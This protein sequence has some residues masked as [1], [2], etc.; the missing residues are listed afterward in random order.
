MTTSFVFRGGAV[1]DGEQELTGDVAVEVKGASIE[2]VG[3][4]G[5]MPADARVVDLRGRFL[6]PGLIDAHV[7]IT[8]DSHRDHLHRFRELTPYT[9]IRA[10]VFTR[11]TLLNGFTTLRDVGG[12]GYA[13]VAVKQAIEDGLIVGPRLLSAGHHL[14][15]T[16]RHEHGRWR[17]EVDIGWDGRVDSPDE[18]R[19]AARRDLYYGADLIKL[20]ATGNVHS[21][22]T[23][24]H[25]PEL[26]IEEMRAAVEAAHA[27]HKRVAVHAHGTDGIKNAVRAGCDTVEHASFLDREA[28]HMIRDRSVSIVPTLSF[29]HQF[30]ANGRERGLAEYAE[31]KA[32]MVRDAL[33]ESVRLA[34][35]AGVP[36]VLG[37]DTGMQFLHHGENA[38]ELSYMVKVGLSSTQALRAGTSVAAAAL[39][40]GDRVGRIRPGYQADLLVVNGNPLHDV[41]VL[42]DPARIE[43]VM[44]DGVLYKEEGRS[45]V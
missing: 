5:A 34:E 2:A 22:G 40:L 32:L 45:L 35:E 37:T 20:R 44:R 29:V 33:F 7:H 36:I 16:G 24:P 41:R 18:A 38:Q 11:Q 31:R 1:F 27:R 25:E 21:E 14:S 39:G 6:M 10:G 19:R 43:W 13:N 9:A 8:W 3:P 23:E 28:I 30:L 26:T 42:C 12:I 4:A 15:M 17:P